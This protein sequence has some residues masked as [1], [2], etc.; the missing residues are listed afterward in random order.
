MDDT[1]AVLEVQRLRI[2]R[3][4]EDRNALLKASSDLVDYLDAWTESDLPIGY[5]SLSTLRDTITK[6]KQ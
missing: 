1:L 4:Q 5:K 3:L 2:Q 6:V